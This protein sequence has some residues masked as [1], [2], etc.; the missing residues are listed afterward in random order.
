MEN[1]KKELENSRNEAINLTLD[2]PFIQYQ[3]DNE[4]GL[5]IQKMDAIQI[6]NDLVNDNKSISFCDA[7]TTRAN[8]LL[9]ATLSGDAFLDCLAKIYR[10]QKRYIE[11]NGTNALFLCVGFLKWKDSK[12][13]E[14][15]SPLI[16]I[17]VEISR[18]ENFSNYFISYS[19]ERI[20]FN[21]CLRKKVKLEYGV[22]LDLKT[23]ED[24]QTIEDQLVFIEKQLKGNLKDWKVE[25]DKGL[26][27]QF[28]YGR[29]LIADDLDLS[30]WE[31]KRPFQNNMMNKLF[32]SDK[33][34]SS[35]EN[36]I[37]N[38]D[39]IEEKRIYN[40]NVYQREAL[41]TIFQNEDC[42]IE[43]APGTGKAQTIAN[44]IASYVAQGKSVL[45]VSKKKVALD[46]MNRLLETMGLADLVLELHTYKTNKKD[47]LK[48]IEKTLALGSPKNILD[49]SLSSQYEENK[50][51][52]QEIY[53]SL[54]YKIANSDMTFSTILGE[55]LEIKDALE[56]ENIRIPK[57]NI[58]RFDEMSKAHFEECLKAIH[59]YSEL[60]KN[61]GILEKHPFIYIKGKK[62]TEANKNTLISSLDTMDTSL[63][64]MMENASAMSK[65]WTKPMLTILDGNRFNESIS[66]LK[67]HE[68]L[69]NINVKDTEL[70]NYFDSIL[71]IINRIKKTQKFLRKIDVKKEVFLTPSRYIALYNR[72]INEEIIEKKE[73]Y[74]TSLKA[75]F[76]SELYL[77]NKLKQV[78]TFLLTKANKEEDYTLLFHIFKNINSEN[79]FTFDY[80]N[81]KALL[82]EAIAFQKLVSEGHILPQAKAYI[83]DLEKIQTL[84]EY[85]HLY[86]QAKNIFVKSLKTFL[87]VSQYDCF[88]KFDSKTF[89]EDM[90]FLELR[91][92]VTEWKEKENHISYILDY[93][94]IIERIK[95]LEIN[96]ILNIHLSPKKMKFLGDFF[97]MSYYEELIEHAYKQYPLL[98]EIKRTRIEK[99]YDNLLEFD[100]KSMIENAKQIVKTHYEEMQNVKNNAKEMNILRRETLKK[101]N[102]MPVKKLLLRLHESVQKIKPIFIT[103]PV[104]ISSF[105]MGSDMVFDLVVFNEASRISAY[106]GLNAML[107]AKRIVAF[108]DSNEFAPS[109]KYSYSS[110]LYSLS[111]MDFLKENGAKEIYLRYQY[112]SLYA[113]LLHFVNQQYYNERLLY[114]PSAQEYHNNE[115]FVLQT[116][117]NG[118]Y[119]SKTKVNLPEVKKIAKACLDHAKNNP[120][121]SLGV[122]CL[123]LP[124]QVQLS[125]ELEKLLAKEEDQKIKDFFTLHKNEP[126]FMK[127]VFASQGDDR[128]VIFVSLVYAKKKD[129][130]LV[131]DFFPLVADSGMS[132]LNVAITG[133][134]RK[135][136][137]FSSLDSESLEITNQTPKGIK[138]LYDLLRML[139]EKSRLT[140][141]NKEE[142]TLPNKPTPKKKDNAFL[143]YLYEKITEKGYYID[144][145]IGKQCGIDLAIAKQ[146][147]SPFIL[148]IELDNGVYYQMEDLL[149]RDKIRRQL[150]R[151]RGWR[152]IHVWSSEFVK[153]PKGELDKIFDILES[154]IK[155]PPLNRDLYSFKVSR[156]NKESS[157]EKI[158]LH[159]VEYEQ[160]TTKKQTPLILND[161]AKLALYIE[162]IVRL[163]SPIPLALLKKRLCEIAD[164]DKLSDEE[165][166]TI[167]KLAQKDERFEL[168]NDFIYWKMNQDFY[169]RN[170]SKLDSA[171]KKV[172]YIPDEELEIAITYVLNAGL[173]ATE[174]ELY[175]E[176][177]NIFGFHKNARLTERLQYLVAL[178]LERGKLYLD[179]G[180]LYLND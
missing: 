142:G 149:D 129:G 2:N 8:G 141:K 160:F 18:V 30:Y 56:K 54:S 158:E 118:V 143:N 40:A 1:I 63:N 103:S 91:K 122:I 178:L 104:S 64:M 77:E 41:K 4:Y 73:C 98:N 144:T 45:Y 25:R 163:E 71:K 151:N 145:E 55:Y 10:Q 167:N 51:R 44:L 3:K 87:E 82:E 83:N 165:S 133:A 177:G 154:P 123:N 72:Y 127:D 86:N 106:E 117:T 114:F 52:I 20:L 19:G 22:D 128:D 94:A 166:E 37:K 110:L 68:G 147:N 70:E 81:A 85:N 136:V 36:V 24:L 26:L 6:Y 78:Q 16:L 38:N 33:N 13:N 124:Q 120:S 46:K 173:V 17:P 132:A 102:Q 150:L 84:S 39:V 48:K 130:E 156:R 14:L 35:S 69:K 137:I 119:D 89:Y 80:A 29:Y 108:G 23:D 11:E 113:S 88:A 93:N 34:P 15:E 99:L 59:T 157:E 126:F 27:S 67:A 131:E 66:T 57:I 100:Q 50:K 60:S 21:M 162:K 42:V 153:N 95:D 171:S 97:T 138:N 180:L 134:R 79:V 47:V 175:K 31:D 179:N 135:C 111:V 12:E 65:I 161:D 53:E 125:L 76:T 174:Q 155:F 109:S 107:R 115:S 139:E 121:L 105:L 96:S 176:I 112:R 172:D 43:A 159:L 61:L 170:R 148:G 9:K 164:V 49:Q 7:S 146:E 90:N 75:C 5:L 32:P 101:R 74:L 28:E 140:L 62:N 169:V 168:K 116:I 92:L 152:V 58:F